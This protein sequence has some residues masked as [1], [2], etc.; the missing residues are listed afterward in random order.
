MLRGTGR[1]VLFTNVYIDMPKPNAI[2]IKL[3]SSIC[4]VVG[5]D[6]IFILSHFQSLVT[7]PPS[8]L[9]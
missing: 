4:G 9:R 5:F 3:S 1:E 8:F 6:V 7:S 2:G